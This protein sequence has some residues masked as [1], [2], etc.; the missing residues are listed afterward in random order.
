MRTAEPWAA[1]G[2]L[3]RLNL[4]LDRVRILVW[5]LA[6]TGTVSATVL[7]LEETFPDGEARQ[8]RAALLDNPS[9]VMMTGPAFGADDYTLGAMTVNELS[10]SVLVATA[11]MSILLASRH[12]TR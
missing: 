7:A 4:R 10:L 12:E 6:L 3:F 11:I 2:R 1:T 9:A 5:V 8:A